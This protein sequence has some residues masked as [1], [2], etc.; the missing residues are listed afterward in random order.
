[1][2]YGKI[3]LSYMYNNTVKKSSTSSRHFK[4]VHGWCEWIVDADGMDFGVA[5]LN[6]EVESDGIA[7]YSSLERLLS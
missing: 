5:D 7:R 2:V 1:M 6:S 4:R 3:L